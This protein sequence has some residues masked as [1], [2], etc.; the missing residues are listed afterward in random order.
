M[1]LAVTLC[2]A[3]FLGEAV[4][5]RR[6][7]AIAV[8]FVGVIIIVQPGSEGFTVYSLW[9]IAAVCCMVVR[10]LSTR[11]LLPGIPSIFLALTTGV[12]I[13]AVAGLVSAT[14][15]WE[16]VSGHAGGLLMVAAIFLVIGYLFNVLSMRHGE[17]GFV[18]PFR[19]TILIWAI[20]LGFVVFGDV[21]N[22]LTLIGSVIVVATGVYTF[23]RE[24]Q[25]RLRTAS[26][27]R[28]VR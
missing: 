23:Y 10:D 20:L 19:Y 8:G 2:A 24:R 16:P 3:L 22:A 26:A 14:R 13:T 15:P 9:A 21:P 6:Y 18:S 17:I 11:R 5:W 28:L 12:G 27:V 4:G 7:S 1:P 25:L